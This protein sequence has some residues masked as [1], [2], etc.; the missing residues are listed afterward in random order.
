MRSL[1]TSEFQ[2]EKA[3]E[4]KGEREEKPCRLLK[5][6]CKG[7]FAL[8]VGGRL[9][10]RWLWWNHHTSCYIRRVS[11]IWEFLKFLVTGRD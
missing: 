11:L 8:G 6:N 7:S 1:Q 10:P 2:K 9:E 5:K 3:K 4:R